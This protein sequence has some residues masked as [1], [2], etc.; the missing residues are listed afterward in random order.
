[1]TSQVQGPGE[2]PEPAERLLA[3][4][5]RL[6]PSWLERAT[7]AAAAAGGVPL[8]DDDAELGTVVTEATDHLLTELAHLLATDVDEQRTNPLSLFRDAIAGPTALLQRRHVPPPASDPFVADRFPADV[9]GLGPAAWADIDPELHESGITWGAWKAMT[10][11]RRRRE[12]GL[13]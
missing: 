12:E 2:L 5:R 6:A 1:M 13:R 3:D 10:V 4:T 7:R 9:Y 8:P 11:L